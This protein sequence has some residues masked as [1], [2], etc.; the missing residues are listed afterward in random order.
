MICSQVGFD[1]ARPTAKG[2]HDVEFTSTILMQ[3]ALLL[4]TSISP[5]DVNAATQRVA[6]FPQTGATRL[7]RSVTNWRIPRTTHNESGV[8]TEH[9]GM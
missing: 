6:T 1:N 4:M 3:L 5:L 2:D 9:W 7:P 8:D